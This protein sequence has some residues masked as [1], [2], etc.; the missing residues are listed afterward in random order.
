MHKN[1]TKSN[2]QAQESIKSAHQKKTM[3]LEAARDSLLQD[4]D[5]LRIEKQRYQM[6]NNGLNSEL[7]NKDK[8][9]TKTQK[10]LVKYQNQ[11]A[12]HILENKNNEEDFKN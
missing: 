1:E 11:C 3:S 6:Q 2:Q 12:K 7:D 10:E 4:N 8:K 9:L 5:E